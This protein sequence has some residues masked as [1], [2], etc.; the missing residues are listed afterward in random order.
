MCTERTRKPCFVV[1]GS[2]RGTPKVQKGGGSS[3]LSKKF[4]S[5]LLQVILHQHRE[6]LVDAHFSEGYE[7]FLT[8]GAMAWRVGAKSYCSLYSLRPLPLSPGYR[9]SHGKCMAHG[10]I[11]PLT[12]YRRTMKVSCREPESLGE[13][14]ESWERGGVGT[15]GLTRVIWL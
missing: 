4:G 7:S 13:I 6:R 3:L 8:R 9:R 2:E 1:Q 5:L 14:V 11:K 10:Q 15:P 12:F